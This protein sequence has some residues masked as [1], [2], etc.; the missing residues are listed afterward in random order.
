MTSS[1]R[2]AQVRTPSDATKSL[3]ITVTAKHLKGAK[4]CDGKQ[5]VLAK[6]FAD[7]ILGEFGITAEVGLTI[8]KLTFAGQ[9]KRY[10]TPVALRPA[11]R[12]FDLTGMWDLEPGD[13]TFNPPCK[14]ARLGGRPNRW[15]KHQSGTDGS[16]RDS[17][18]PRIAP[19]RTISRIQA[20]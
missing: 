4:Q 11:I 17:M 15:H 8:T 6:A 1:I 20:A 19:T 14:T 10:A 12:N 13:F 9:T 3:T 5:C 2:V 16:G 7:S 18:K